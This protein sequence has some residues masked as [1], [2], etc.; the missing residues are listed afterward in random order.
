MTETKNRF[1]KPNIFRTS[2][3]WTVVFVLLLAGLSLLRIWLMRYA[4]WYMILNSNVDDE[5]QV[6]NAIAMLEG[7]W[8]GEY[9]NATIAKHPSYPFFLAAMHWLHIPYPIGFA[10]LILLAGAVFAA[11]LRPVVKNRWIR[12]IIYLFLI[13]NP[14]GFAHDFA[15][16]IYRNS[17]IPWSVLLLVGCIVGLY[18]RK[19]R[20][21]RIQLAWSAGLSA[22]AAFF[23]FLR[24]DSIWMV[25]FL[26]AGMGLLVLY[27]VAQWLQGKKRGGGRIRAKRAASLALVAALPFLTLAG[28]KFTISYLNKINYGVFMTEDRVEASIGD[29]MR[30]LYRLDDGVDWKAK[31]D[32]EDPTVWV[33]SIAIQ[34]A[35][36]ASPAFAQLDNLMACYMTLSGGK[37][38][39]ADWAEWAIRTA[40][41]EKGYYRDA[42]ETEIYFAIVADELEQAFRDGR[43]TQKE[44]IFLSSQTGAF[45]PDDFEEA[46]EITGVTFQN[47]LRYQFCDPANVVID[48]YDET[49]L[50]KWEE[51]LQT[52]VPR[53][54][55]QLAMIYPAAEVGAADNADSAADASAADEKQAPDLSQ[56][57]EDVL[58]SNALL[59]SKHDA[60]YERGVNLVAVYR[61]LHV[62]FTVL[63]IAGYL[64]AVIW[65]MVKRTKTPRAVFDIWLLQSGLLLNTLLDIYIVSLFS[66]ALTPNP[67]AN[68]FCFYAMSGYTM[69]AAVTGL[70]L[71][72]AVLAVKSFLTK[73]KSQNA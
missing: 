47:M 61:F 53:T 50:L 6:R 16:R 28:A 19:D 70:S 37:E 5:M 62:P 35:Q 17:L 21:L 24:E 7:E 73:V 26:V 66:K 51:L 69:L 45:M 25:P 27:W 38:I 15:M 54:E 57:P 72:T 32:P 41:A 39:W 13:Y 14:I 44:G 71:C 20:K 2:A 60:A 40:A 1:S 33:S 67:M 58:H 36:E 9:S 68:V 29:V 49:K 42:L 48:F 4:G 59:Q 46:W 10:L 43:L 12:G 3:L 55:E 34:K 31:R 56:V 11:S 18:L 30:C 8:M 22:S 64:L 52:K 23:W 63:M 65:M